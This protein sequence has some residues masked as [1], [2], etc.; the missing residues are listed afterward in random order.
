[1]TCEQ[2]I[3]GVLSAA[4]RLRNSRSGNPRWR[5]RVSG[6]LYT[7]RLDSQSACNID[8]TIHMGETVM[9]KLDKLGFIRDYTVMEPVE[10]IR[11]PSCDIYF[12]SKDDLHDHNLIVHRIDTRPRN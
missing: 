4:T 11:C 8:P 9:I 1:M 6:Q 7:T 5:L 10:L 12:N 3:I 2:V